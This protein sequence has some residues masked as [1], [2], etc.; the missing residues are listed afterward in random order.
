MI[1]VAVQ[2]RIIATASKLPA[3]DATAMTMTAMNVTT[4]GTLLWMMLPRNPPAAC[5]L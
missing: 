5:L 3:V 4:A 2:I 1:T